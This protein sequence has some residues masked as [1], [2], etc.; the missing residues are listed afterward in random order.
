MLSG[1]SEY[2]RP[3]LAMLLLCYRRKMWRLLED[4]VYLYTYGC[5][6]ETQVRRKSNTL[7]R[8]GGRAKGKATQNASRYVTDTLTFTTATTT[9]FVTLL[10]VI[11]SRVN[12]TCSQGRSLGHASQTLSSLCFVFECHLHA[13]ED[14]RDWSES[15]KNKV[16]VTAPRPYL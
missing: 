1:T 15:R 5:T 13:Y 9:S 3:T 4:V 11:N 7:G 16:I 8:A 10:L 12:Y 6:H 2:R 14:K